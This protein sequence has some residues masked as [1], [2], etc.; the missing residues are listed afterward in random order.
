[1]DKKSSLEIHTISKSPKR[2][3][4]AAK[5]AIA[6]PE[7]LEYGFDGETS[8]LLER[9]YVVSI[10]PNSSQNFIATV[11][12]FPTAGEA[13]RAGLRLSMALLWAAIS[14]KWPLK[15]EYHTPQPCMVYDRTQNYG[16]GF[17]FFASAR[18]ETTER[19]K[20][21]GLVSALEPLATLEN[22]DN[23]ELDDIVSS[24][25]SEIDKAESIPESVK[26]S[27]R[28]RA[29]YLK[30]ESISQAITRFVSSHFD[31]Q[32]DVLEIVRDAYNTR[33]RILHEGVYDADLD[34]KGN[35]LEDII[36][37]IYSKILDIDLLFKSGIEKQA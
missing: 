9:P 32:Q 26:S 1:M 21:I 24:F 16:G 27:V 18:L 2:R 6:L 8:L 25:V 29:N 33:S 19:S 28:S 30:S 10:K 11:E 4:Y 12:G 15:L 36:R 35:K 7:G 13:E 22:F 3:P 37:Q 31:N 14:R 17:S 5:I 20:F 34:E 23:T